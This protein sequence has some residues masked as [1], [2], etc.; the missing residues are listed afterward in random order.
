[1]YTVH[2][3]LHYSLGITPFFRLEAGIGYLLSGGTLSHYYITPD[4]FATNNTSTNTYIYSGAITLPLYLKFTKPMPRG[5]YTCTF[6]PDFYLPV[7][8]FYY[9]P[10]G[11]IAGEEA[12]VSHAHTRF[13][14]DQVGQASTM[15]MYLK[16]GYEKKL[17]GSS[18]LMINVGPVI[19]FN[20]LVMF[21]P[22][23]DEESYLGYHPYQFYTGL[24]VAL[25][26]G[27]KK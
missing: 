12:P 3:Q 5:A 23:D 2:V 14:A 20:Q 22:G 11:A 15:G 19:D 27:L 21:H 25:T 16:M 17:P 4:G 18:H 13:T 1:M 26:F 7:H 9:A 10:S 8:S 6:G 24:D